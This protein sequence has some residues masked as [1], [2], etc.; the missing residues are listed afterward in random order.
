MCSKEEAQFFRSISFVCNPSTTSIWATPLERKGTGEKIVTILA[1]F[2]KNQNSP[3]KL[4]FL[5]CSV[6][7]AKARTLAYR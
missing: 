7:I 4:S 5:I 3:H 6:S 2:F 1:E